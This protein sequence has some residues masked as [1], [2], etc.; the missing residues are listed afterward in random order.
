M[1]EQSLN[2]LR[3]LIE[4][5]SPS[6]FEQPAQ[7]VV[8]EYITP[9]VDEVRTDVHGNV[10]AIR[11]PE[12]FPRVMLAGHVDQIG[13]MVQHITDEGFIYFGAIGGIDAAVMPGLSVTVHNA[14]GPVPGVIGRR[15]IHLLKPEERT[16]PRLDLSDMWIDLG[17]ADRAETEKLIEVGDP[18]TFNLRL[19]PLAQDLVCGPGLDD[20]VGTFVV[21]EALRLLSRRRLSCA[22]YSVSTVQEELGLRGARTSAY[23]IDPQVGIAVDVTHATDYPGCDPK[24]GGEVKLKK[25]PTIARGP[26]INPV[27]QGLMQEVAAAKKIPYQPDPE[28]R[29]TGTDANA[30]QLTRAGVATALVS[31]PNRYMHTPVEIVA[32]SDLEQAARLLAETVAAIGPDH[33]FTPL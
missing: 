12:G 29:G 7:R 6:G 30:I 4:T 8:R 26:N 24:K 9:C 11:N 25:G 5:P 15:P 22:L 13:L 18:V 27:L 1:R 14:R 19:Q 20:K 10:M 21:M 33:D 31:I 2:F 3:N 16:N 17:T 32:L 23:G 28:P